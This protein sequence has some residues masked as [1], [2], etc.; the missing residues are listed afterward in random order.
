MDHG[1]VLHEVAPILLLDEATSAWG[2]EVEVAIQESL[3]EM[4]RP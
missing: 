4:A 2:S 3:D 1:L